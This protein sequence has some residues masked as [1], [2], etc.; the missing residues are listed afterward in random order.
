MGQFDLGFVR[1]VCR[2]T[3]G[4]TQVVQ[5]IWINRGIL[6]SHF[7]VSGPSSPSMHECLQK[8]IATCQLCC[9]HNNPKWEAG[10]V[11]QKAQ[12]R[13]FHVCYSSNV[14]TDHDLF[15]VNCRGRGGRRQKMWPDLFLSL[16]IRFAS[17]M[18]CHG[19]LSL[20]HSK[21]GPR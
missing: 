20:S 15:I 17:Y 5:V 7:F 19:M 13:N 12:G 6:Q 1:A 9:A 16:Y 2:T 11:A 18:N 4:G 10:V 8:S 21:D 14:V 3:G